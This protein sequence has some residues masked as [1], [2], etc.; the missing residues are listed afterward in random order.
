MTMSSLH[1]KQYL[2][3]RD[4]SPH[5]RVILQQGDKPANN[6]IQC[7]SRHVIGC[8]PDGDALDDRLAPVNHLTNAVRHMKEMKNFKVFQI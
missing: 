5:S 4:Q 7:I 8:T 1:F 6:M 2:V 3:K